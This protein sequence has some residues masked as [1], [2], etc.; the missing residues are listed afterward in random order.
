MTPYDTVIL[1][2]PKC[3]KVFPVESMS[4]QRLMVSYPL[5]MA[6]ADV[7]EGVNDLAPYQCKSCGIRFYVK[8]FEDGIART[9]EWTDDVWPV[10]KVR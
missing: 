5:P 10:P 3:G 7:L 4:G 6:P 1:E 8:R 2:C 9:V